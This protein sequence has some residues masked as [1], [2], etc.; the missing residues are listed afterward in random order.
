[1]KLILAPMATICHEA[2]RRC[3]ERFGGV[4]EYFTEMIN[5]STLVNGG[6]FEKYY[7]Q[8]YTAPEKIVWQLTGSSAEPLCK[9]AEMVSQYGGLGMDINM[10]CSAPQI[11]KTGAGIA[12]MEK[13]LL[14]TAAMVKK[15]RGALDEHQKRTGEHIR[16]SVKC[17]LGTADFCNEE[18]FFAFTDM[19]VES[20]VELITL[21]P[22]LK[23]EKYRGLPQYVLA[24]RL[25]QRYCAE[26][27][28]F[29]PVPVYL[30]GCICDISSANNALR[31]APSVHG[32]MIAR[33]AVQKPW[34]FKELHAALVQKSGG[35]HIQEVDALELAL[36]FILDVE[37]FQPQEFW[38]T[39]L[40]RFFSYYS[41]NFSFAHYFKTQMCNAKDTQDLRARLAD[42]FEKQKEDRFLF[43]PCGAEEMGV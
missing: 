9:A 33:A 20:G 23:K 36:Q 6:P 19:L 18:T 5:A 17:R 4:D 22:R 37:Q 24:E 7:V 12:W 35:E 1:M 31:I 26:Q 10:G 41:A 11:Y 39:R 2:F 8:Q 30:N 21:H 13:P 16:L 29:L 3:V 32:L 28:H 27:T 40:Q 43:F 42:Y 38:K 25:A 15:I 34:I 14:E